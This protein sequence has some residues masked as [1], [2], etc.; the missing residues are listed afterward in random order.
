LG[1]ISTL[2]PYPAKNG[3]ERSLFLPTPLAVFTLTPTFSQRLRKLSE[4]DMARFGAKFGT[5]TLDEGDVVALNEIVRF[6]ALDDVSP[7]ERAGEMVRY[8][9]VVYA[10]NAMLWTFEGA[11]LRAKEAGTPLLIAGGIGHQTPFL[12]AAVAQSRY[13]G[14]AVESRPEACILADIAIR[15]WGLPP[16]RILIEDRSRNSGENAAF[17]LALLRQTPCRPQRVL[18]IQD[19]L[20]QRRTFAT[21]YKV[22]RGDDAV[23]FLNWPVLVPSLVREDDTVRIAAPAGL[24]LWSPEQFVA[25]LL[26]EVIRLRDDADGYGPRGRGY[27]DHVDV[28]AGVESAYRQ[29]T[30][31]SPFRE[32]AASRQ[33]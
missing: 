31:K 19:P 29:L 25:L 18:L 8:D 28:P 20:M 2:A 17:S 13:C 1:G 12:R 21:F 24:A 30:G 6:L 5:M 10:G 14:V 16:G 27:I 23:V 33:V 32:L 9:L 11:A 3:V 4:D 15:W 7:R 26:G 22:W